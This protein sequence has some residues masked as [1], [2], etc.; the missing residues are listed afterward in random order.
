LTL[1]AKWN[2]QQFLFDAPAQA[3]VLDGENGL[4]AA[5]EIARHPIGAAGPNSGR[6][7]FSK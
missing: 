5:E 1:S 6:P 4:D 2:G 7:P 3:G